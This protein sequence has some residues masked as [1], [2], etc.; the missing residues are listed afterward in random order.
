MASS[1]DLQTYQQRRAA[2][3]DEMRKHGG[4]AMLLPAGEERIRNN[5]NEY[6]FRQDSDYA[7]LTGFEEPTGCALLVADPPPG[8]PGFVMFV[9]PRD[10]DR[11]IW[12]GWRA[13][14][15]GAKATYGADEAYTVAEMEERLPGLLEQTGT[16]WY[17]LGCSAAWDARMAGLL[18]GLRAKA[19]T[20]VTPPARIFDPALVLH[21]LRLVKG[22]DE[23]A[24]LRRAVQ[25]TVEGH[26]AAMHRGRP[27]AREYQVQAEIEFTFRREGATGPGYGT[28]VAAGPSSCILHY[29]AGN[30]PL[31]QGQV[32]LVDAGAEFQLYTGD[33]TRTFPVGGKFTPA[34]RALY[35]LVLEVQ[36][37]AIAS[38]K[39]GATL[40][41]IHE[42]VVRRLTEGLIH[43]ELLEGSA[44]ERIADGSIRRYYMHRTSH[45]LGMDV[46][47]VGDYFSG[48]KSRPLVPGMVATIEP[49]LYVAADDEKAPPEMRGVGIRIED[50]VLVT[51]EGGENLTIACPKTAAEVEAACDR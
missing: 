25:I 8:K 7:Y 49:G 37:E 3:V 43:L 6:P 38:V 12:T 50:D 35:D 48:G 16:L 36:R 46:H 19:R 18:N 1:F 11:E 44:E 30:E 51:P 5:D 23:L 32:C 21:A 33:V 27:G 34:Q 41:G 2:I 24:C 9:R 17:R 4:G 22:P 42:Q 40:D 13:G 47:D 29:R 31:Q 26:L 15:E 20:G 14:V 45:W 39:P 10:R 28:I